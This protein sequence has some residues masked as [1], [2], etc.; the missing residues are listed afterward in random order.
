MSHDV[1]AT[2]VRY[3]RAPAAE[4]MPPP[5]LSVHESTLR[6]FYAAELVQALRAEP[7][8][9][10]AYL[11]ALLT[12]PGELRAQPFAFQREIA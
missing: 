2:H 6:E 9:A 4:P 8:P 10:E 5:P 3:G 1:Y 12:M 11:D 7:R